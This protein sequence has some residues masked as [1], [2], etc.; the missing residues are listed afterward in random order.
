MYVCVCVR[1][2]IV[3]LNSSQNKYNLQCLLEKNLHPKF[4]IQR[5]LTNTNMKEGCGKLLA[6]IKHVVTLDEH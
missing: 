1:L 3:L 4:C 6:N 2:G 5:V